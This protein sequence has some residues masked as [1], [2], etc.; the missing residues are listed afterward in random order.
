M[1]RPNIHDL[2]ESG[3][4]RNKAPLEGI[5][6]SAY[7]FALNTLHSPL[8]QEAVSRIANTP[9]LWWARKMAEQVLIETD[10]QKIPR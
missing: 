10:S 8:A 4:T 2:S 6:L 9:G 5:A 1:T 3:I 7:L